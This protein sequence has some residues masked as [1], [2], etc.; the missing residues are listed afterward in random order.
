MSPTSYFASSLP[1]EPAPPPTR[2]FGR[3]KLVKEIVNP[4]DTDD[5]T[6]IALTGTGGIGKTSATLAVLCDDRIKQR[7]G[8]HR[9]FLHCDQFAP[10]LP[11]FFCRLSEV[12]GAGIENSMDLVPL[13]PL[14]CQRKMLLIVDNAES[15]LSDVYN[16][17]AMGH[18]HQTK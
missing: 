14:L 3:D 4:V 12:I 11:N 13:R 8:H 9:R 10:S 5:L 15:L 7:F 6:P 18:R 17:P 1:G 2:I 16:S